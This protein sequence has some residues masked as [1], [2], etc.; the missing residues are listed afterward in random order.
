MTRFNRTIM[1][2]A[3]A[4]GTA[5]IAG[6][7]SAHDSRIIDRTQADQVQ[8]IDQLRRSGQLTRREHAVL[9]AE[10]ARI[11]ALE[12]DAQRDG[13][14]NGREYRTIREAQRQASDHIYQESHNGRVNYWRLWKS[15]H[16]FGY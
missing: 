6:T 5:G 8:Q 15:R 12:Q 13:Y 4:A 10:Q 9:M 11:A 2:L 16:G 7:A 1:A 14:I 3:L